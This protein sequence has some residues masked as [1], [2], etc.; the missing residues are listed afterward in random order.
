MPLSA[1]MPAPLSTT[2][3]FFINK[4]DEDENTILCD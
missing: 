2:S 3:F 4:K 1:L